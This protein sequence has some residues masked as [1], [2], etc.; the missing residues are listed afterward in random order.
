MPGWIADF[1]R[2]WW[3][4][5]Y[6]NARK[7]AFRWRG[8]R[9]PCQNPSDSG[10]ALETACDA[11]MSWRQP[12]RFQRVCPLLVPTPQGLRCGVDTKDVRPFWGRAAGFYG[13]S[14][15]AV[16]LTA[17]LGAFAFLRGIGYPVRFMAVAWPPAWRE[18]RA[19]RSEYFYQ[20]A[21]RALTANR[22]NEA[23]ISLMMAYDL[24]PRSYQAG[25][26][27]ARLW[28]VSQPGLSDRVYLRLLN[29]DPEQA[30]LIAEAW[31]RALLARG[32]FA[33]IAQVAPGFL[34]HDIAH[35]SVWMYALF[36]ATR[37]TGDTKPLQLLLDENSALPA[38][39]RRLVE[40]ELLAETGR[41][42]DAHA[43]LRHLPVDTLQAA[44]YQIDELTVLGFP[45]DAL[46]ALEHN[47]AAISERDRVALR[48]D[49]FATKGW[50]SLVRNEVELILTTPVTPSSIELLC[51]HFIRHPD[52][53]LLAA[54]F[55]KLQR[56]PLP[57]NTETYQATLALFC[58]AGVNADWVDLRTA[59][60]TLRQLSGASFTTL[61]V[62]EAFFRG[63][64]AERRLGSVL[65]VLQPLALD[66]TYS[67][68]DHYGGNQPVARAP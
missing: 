25:L 40:I 64:S 48:L 32:D 10:R 16:Y 8:G 66:V 38:N 52:A 14:L 34:V 9:C 6:W 30:T 54:L 50:P 53:E 43:A 46:L 57:P 13:G 15:A 35:T 55:D 23:I 5:L 67:L 36:F 17:V 18:I 37:S 29:D 59:R 12:G 2:F 20:K 63:K 26:L 51:T 11:C 68:F 56:T 7:T 22:M 49:A 41:T 28:Q 47:S 27:L 24:N 39:L 62:A 65:P 3:S 33:K 19:A 31:Y 58:A 44:Y 61:D 21:G 1:L 45:D 60:N 42:S 4:L